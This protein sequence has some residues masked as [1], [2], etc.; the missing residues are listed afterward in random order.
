LA[1]YF[2]KDPRKVV[3][4]GDRVSV[5]LIEVKLDKQQIAPVDE[6]RR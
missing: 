1:D 2:V 5:R 6:V 3:N 4:A